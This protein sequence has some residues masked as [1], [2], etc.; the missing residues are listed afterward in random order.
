MAVFMC[1]GQGAQK[2]GMGADLLDRPEVAAAF[3]TGSE[4]L[5]IDLAKLAQEGSAEEITDTFN[6]Q[7]LTM[8]VS[9]GVGNTLKAAGVQPSA[10]LGFSLGQISAL[11]LAE[12]LSTEDAFKLLD[13][14]A[15]AMREA[16]RARSGAMMALLGAT[17]EDAQELAAQAAGED[18]LVVANYN[19]P[20]QVVVSGDVA[21]IDRAEAIWSERPK[22]RYSRLKTDGAFHSP[23]MQPAVEPIRACCEQL[24]F[25]EPAV[26]LICNTDARPFVATEAAERL[27]AQVV[28]PVHFQQSMEYLIAQGE[29]EFVET[30]FGGVLFNLTKRISKEVERAKAGTAA[31]LDAYLEAHA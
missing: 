16:C 20:G 1:S 10:V 29:T 30:G 23:L 3:A 2:P 28:S 26:P 25:A 12:V 17:I 15:R 7:A 31:E 13:V 9:V 22:S 14:R 11:A 19:C 24:A 8:A 27:S 5:G 21:A 4:V 6:A 18:T